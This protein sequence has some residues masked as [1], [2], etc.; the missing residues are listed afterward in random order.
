MMMSTRYFRST[1][2]AGFSLV[3]LMIAMTIGL[4]LTSMLAI[5]FQN[6]SK[7]NSEQFLAAEQQENGRFAMEMLTN[8]L[9]TAGFYGEFGTLPPAGAALAG[10][11]TIP[12]QTEITAATSDSPMAFY[13]QG[14]PAASVAASASIP[15]GC[16]AWIDSATLKPGSDILVVRRLSTTPLIDSEASPAVLSATAVEGE[17][18]AQTSYGTMSI[19][20]GAGAIVD[21]SKKATGVATVLTRKDFSQA[22]AGTP[23][24]RPTTAAYIRKLQVHVYFVAKCR[25]GSGTNGKCTAADDDIPTLKRLE[26]GP[27][28]VHNPSMSLVPLVEGIEFMKVYYGLDTTSAISGKDL[29][30]IVDSVV[31]TPLTVADWQ[32]VVMAEL[33]L[34]ARNT[35]TTN[36]YSDTKSYDLGDG[37]TYT[38]SGSAKGF[39]RHA[40]VSRAYIENIAG[41]R[42]FTP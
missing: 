24:V 12:A 35:R 13:V 23:P 27:D 22:A 8:D 29:D 5:V 41:R 11:C 38:P 19:Q 21:G 39:K 16:S 9:R 28:D 4:I 17:I 30:G 15:A 32:N 42:E 14:Y 31:A 6:V 36:N 1:A 34:V 37:I 18:Y 7:A 10:P 25:E 26:L 20:Y 3:E 2:E 33:R 40:F